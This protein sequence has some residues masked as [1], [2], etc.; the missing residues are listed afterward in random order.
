MTPSL[1]NWPDHLDRTAESERESGSKF[2]SDYKQTRRELRAELER[3]MEV[4][5]W[6]L[7]DVT[8]SGGDPGVVIRWTKDGQDYVAACDHYTTKR[9]NLRAAY[10]WIQET[11]KAGD[12]PVKTGRSQFAA[13]ALPSADDAEPAGPPPHEVLNVAPD[14]DDVVVNAAARQLSA[15]YHPDSGEEPDREKFKRVQK[16]KEEL[17]G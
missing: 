12:R 8:G 1:L 5:N 15:K 14:A 2:S 6:R 9:A 3:R 17:L 11:R 16:A 10:L 4:D 13:A 7:D